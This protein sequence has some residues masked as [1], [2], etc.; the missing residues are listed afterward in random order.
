MDN[1]I[2]RVFEKK[3]TDTPATDP[4][5]TSVLTGW[6]ELAWQGLLQKPVPAGRD[7]FRNQR[8][9]AG[10]AGLSGWLRSAHLRAKLETSLIGNKPNKK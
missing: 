1:N 4:F 2:L 3:D 5:A 8:K 6:P 9:W 7:W 10:W